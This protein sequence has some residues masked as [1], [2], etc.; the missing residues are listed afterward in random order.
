MPV[1]SHR[2]LGGSFGSS[3]SGPSTRAGFS[4]PMHVAIASAT[5]PSTMSSMYAD[6]GGAPGVPVGAAAAR[7]GN[8]QTLEQIG[9]IDMNPIRLTVTRRARIRE[10]RNPGAARE[11]AARP[12]GIL[13]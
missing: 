6:A 4:A 7:I 9:E 13:Y 8:A 11:G 12:G 3:R 5:T 1:T 2:G 10:A